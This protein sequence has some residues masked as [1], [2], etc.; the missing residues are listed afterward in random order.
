MKVRRLIKRL[1]RSA[2]ERYVGEDYRDLMRLLRVVKRM[3]KRARR[4]K[5]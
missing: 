5:R 3:C 4:K 2:G 1:E